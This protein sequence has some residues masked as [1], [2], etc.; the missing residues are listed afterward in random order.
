L[1]RDLLQRWFGGCASFAPLQQHSFIC[2]IVREGC[3]DDHD[4]KS[5]LVY[6]GDRKGL[7]PQANCLKLG[8]G[9]KTVQGITREGQIATRNFT[10]FSHYLSA[11]A[12]SAV[13]DSEDEVF[14]RVSQAAEMQ[15]DMMNKSGTHMRLRKRA[16]SNM[17]DSSQCEFVN[18][19]GPYLL[20]FF[21]LNFVVE[22]SG[23][24]SLYKLGLR[25]QGFRVQGLVRAQNNNV[26][27]FLN[28]C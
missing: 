26:D 6:Q 5:H 23:H 18:I 2:T 10:T 8:W 12:I 7:V 11:A 9:S 16:P 25:V 27:W 19:V 21:F 28:G 17:I 15:E 20:K 14:S 13:R 1:H 3:A 24:W 22:V 4:Q